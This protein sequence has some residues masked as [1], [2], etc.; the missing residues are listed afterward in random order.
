[1]TTTWKAGDRVQVSLPYGTEGGTTTHNG[2]IEQVEQA[3]GS[4]KVR[5][6]DP[7]IY[8][9]KGWAWVESQKLA[10]L[11]EKSSEAVNS[12]E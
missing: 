4:V 9:G 12:W 1:M 7:L 3:T 5:F 2:T 10:P 6:D 8:G 11:A